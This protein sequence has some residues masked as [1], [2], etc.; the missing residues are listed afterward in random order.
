MWEYETRFGTFWICVDQP[1]VCELWLEDDRLGNYKNIEEAS[2]AVRFYIQQES[3]ANRDAD[4]ETSEEDW[5]AYYDDLE[6]PEEIEKESSLES[7][8]FIS[9]IGTFQIHSNSVGMYDLR[10]NDICLGIFNQPHQAANAVARCET[11]H[12]KWD[13]RGPVEK[14]SSFSEWSAGF[15]EES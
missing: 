8:H 5:V 6:E 3:G 9:D 4:L 7:W 1:G 13:R 2:E 11:G 15:P 10:F 12:K 14:P